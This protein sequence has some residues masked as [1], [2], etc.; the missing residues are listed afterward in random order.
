MVKFEEMTGQD[1][2]DESDKHLE[3]QDRRYSCLKSVEAQVASQLIF[4]A[5]CLLSF[6]EY[7]PEGLWY[8][9]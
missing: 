9:L 2:Y 3:V 5:G 7:P 4:F 1:D 8:S 6:E